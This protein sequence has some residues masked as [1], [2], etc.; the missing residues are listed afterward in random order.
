MTALKIDAVSWVREARLEEAWAL[1][2]EAFAPL[3]AMTVQRHLMRRLEFDDVMIDH[4]VVKYVAYDGDQMVALS[5][6]T[7]HLDAMPLISPE[8]FARR[9]PAL[10]ADGKVWYCGFVAT[11]STHP[12]AFRALVTAMYRAAEEV[13]GMIGLDVCQYNEDGH[14]LPEI[15]ERL[16]YRISDGKVQVERADTQ[17]YWIYQTGGANNG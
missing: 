16:L 12:G 7:N 11:N 3:N 17:S 4:R 9:W 1:Y 2:V 13:G 15:V 14:R 8:Y 10:Y 6:F 5:T